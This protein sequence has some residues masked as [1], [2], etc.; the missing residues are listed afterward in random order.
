[1]KC[2]SCWSTGLSSKRKTVSHPV[3]RRTCIGV[4]ITI[5]T[6]LHLGRVVCL[7]LNVMSFFFI[8][9][10]ESVCFVVIFSF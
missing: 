2:N 8:Q 9:L 6:Y 4:F 7:M 1:M 10:A 3:Y 5:I